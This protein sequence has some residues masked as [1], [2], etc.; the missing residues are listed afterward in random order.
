MISFDIQDTDGLFEHVSDAIEKGRRA[1]MLSAGMRLVGV[2]QNELIPQAKPHPP[3]DQGAYKAAWHAEPTAT[4]ADVYNDSPHAPIIEYGARAAN[5]KVGRKLIDAL[6]EW[7][8]RKGLAGKGRGSIQARAHADEVRSF[9]FAIAKSMQ[10]FGRDLFR[11]NLRCAC[12]GLLGDAESTPGVRVVEDAGRSRPIHAEP[13]HGLRNRREGPGTRTE[14]CGGR[15]R[16]RNTRRTE[17]RRVSQYPTTSMISRRVSESLSSAAFTGPFGP[18]DPTL[19]RWRRTGAP[20]R[21]GRSP[22]ISRR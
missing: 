13:L 1:G 6:S 16:G 11:H 20:S 12:P 15:D 5:I 9:A 2:I 22:S 21:S 7:I 8:V 17:E 18:R 3:E 4:G 14:D 19:H 10:G